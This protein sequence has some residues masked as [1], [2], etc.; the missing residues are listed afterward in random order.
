MSVRNTI[1]IGHLVGAVKQQAPH[2]TNLRSGEPCYRPA[3]SPMPFNVSTRTTT[4]LTSPPIIISDTDPIAPAQ[5]PS[6]SE[7]NKSTTSF[8]YTCNTIETQP[9]NHETTADNHVKKSP[10]KRHCTMKNHQDAIPS[11]LMNHSWVPLAF[12]ETATSRTGRKRS[13]QLAEAH[14]N[15]PSQHPN[16]KKNPTPD[17]KTP[18]ENITHSASPTI[19][20]PASKRPRRP[21][22]YLISDY[23]WAGSKVKHKPKLW[24]PRR[25]VHTCSSIQSIPSISLTAGN[26]N[27]H[28][29]AG[30]ARKIKVVVKVNRMSQK[31]PPQPGRRHRLNPA[32][33]D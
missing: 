30:P 10:R 5:R 12:K 24:P 13:R 14:P 29:P 20:A 11:S 17:I 15:I 21:P 31:Q 28:A 22:S 33:L 3:I 23:T 4:A 27:D 8:T 2:T 6:A 26:R 1:I 9:P 19:A 7:Q 25:L 18:A 32:Y 16:T